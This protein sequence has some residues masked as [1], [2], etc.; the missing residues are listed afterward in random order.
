VDPIQLG[1]AYWAYREKGLAMPGETLRHELLDITVYPIDL[2]AINKVL[3]DS[4]TRLG[5]PL[6]L[7]ILTGDYDMHGQYTTHVIPSAIDKLAPDNELYVLN[8]FC[9]GLSTAYVAKWDCVAEK[10]LELKFKDIRKRLSDAVTQ[11]PDTG[12]GVIHIGYETVSGPA[13]EFKRQESIQK[14]IRSFDFAEKRIKAVYCNALQLLSTPEGFEWA[15]TVIFN[16]NVPPPILDDRL[17]LDLPGG[18]GSD[19]T[20]WEEDQ[21]KRM[22]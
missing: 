1:G 14:T 22:K 8:E 15:E 3:K 9:A 4:P 12:E 5:S 7:K 11:I 21:E 18:K 17:I 2:E 19:R 6:M 20:H 10:S 13:V 16:E